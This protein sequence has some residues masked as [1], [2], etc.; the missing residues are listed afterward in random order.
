MMDQLIT[1]AP[2][3]RTLCFEPFPDLN[4]STSRPNNVVK[5]IS[6][7]PMKSYDLFLII[8]W[9]PNARS[10]SLARCIFN[11]CQISPIIEHKSCLFGCLLHRFMRS[12]GIYYSVARIVVS[13]TYYKGTHKIHWTAYMF[14][15]LLFTLTPAEVLFNL[16]ALIFFYFPME[17]STSK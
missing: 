9:Y 10:P 15:P 1:S 7:L 5:R 16:Y 8:H 13:N 4:K 12:T 6:P 17:A 11:A 2:T 14:R 3:G